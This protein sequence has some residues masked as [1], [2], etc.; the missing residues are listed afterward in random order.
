[1]VRYC[2]A[3]NPRGFVSPGSPVNTNGRPV[4]IAARAPSGRGGDATRRC[5]RRP[6]V[7]RRTPG[8][9]LQPTP[10]TSLVVESEQALQLLPPPPPPPP[11]S[12]IK[13]C[14]PTPFAFFLFPCPNAVACPPSDRCTNSS[15]TLSE[16]GAIRYRH[17]NCKKRTRAHRDNRRCCSKQQTDGQRRARPHIV[18]TPTF[19]DGFFAQPTTK[20]HPSAIIVR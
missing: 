7:A 9:L 14:T 10:S 16:R 2:A 4:L 12:R 13:Q 17:D 5:P 18:P 15:D 19:V 11:P 6:P 1:M 8:Q 3:A 20:R